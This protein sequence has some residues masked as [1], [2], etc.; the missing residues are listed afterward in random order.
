[1]GFGGDKMQVG[2]LI[3]YRGD[4]WA[5]L[6]LGKTR[7]RIWN[8]KDNRIGLITQATANRAFYP[9]GEINEDR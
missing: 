1:M 5:I 8:V 7:V 3:Y 2:D 9:V 6:E 4:I